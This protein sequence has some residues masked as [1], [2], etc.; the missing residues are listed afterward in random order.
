MLLDLLRENEI[1]SLE[2]VYSKCNCEFDALAGAL[3]SLIEKEEIR[4]GR[5]KTRAGWLIGNK[6][7]DTPAGGATWHTGR[8]QMRNSLPKILKE[9]KKYSPAQEI[10]LDDQLDHN[11]VKSITELLSDGQPRS[12]LQITAATG[13][14]NISSQTWRRFARLPDGRYTLP[15]SSG[16][17]EYFYEYVREKPRR[18]SD[19]LRIFQKHKNIRAIITAGDSQGKLIRLPHALLTTSDSPAGR[20]ELERRRQ[21]KLCNDTLNSLPSPFFTLEELEMNKSIFQSIADKHTVNA[22]LNGKEY[23]CLRR[24]FP[25]DIVTDQLVDITGRYF[26]PPARISAPAFLKTISMGE[27]ETLNFLGVEEEILNQLIQN[28]NIEAFYL[29]GKRRM[30]R[31]DVEQLKMNSPLLRDLSQKHEKLK[32]PRA[33]V[34]LGITTGQVRRL[35]NEGKLEPAGHCSKDANSGQLFTRRNIEEL[36]KSLPE[37]L[38]GW[39]S[40]EKTGGSGSRR[41]GKKQFLAPK[42]PLLR[43]ELTLDNQ[44]QLQL[45]RFQIEAVEALRAGHSVLLSAP[46]GNGKTLVAEILARDLMAAGN[47]MVYTSPLKALSNQ[48]YRDFKETFGLDAVGLVTGDISVNAGAPLLIM[49]TEIFRNWCLGEPEQLKKS[50]YVVFDEIHYLDD[51]ERGTTWE[52]SILFAPPHIKFLGLSATVPNI[53]EIAD[54][55]GSVRREK[56]IIIEEKKRQVPLKIC[57]VTPNGQIVEENEARQEVDELAEYLKAFRNRRQWAEE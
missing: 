53:R 45:D 30:W 6:E 1:L 52:E 34:L 19:L 36:Q 17:R 48:K 37:I 31:N 15:D 28:N 49:T 42:R 18:L 51:S 40:V 4:I 54:W 33:A 2:E 46:T 27:K 20:T 7:I 8:G 11:Q 56:V 32:I 57:W 3:S 13:I 5:L 55:I 10:L 22:V 9:L 47:G 44:H 26:D 25:G 21:L 29:D 41:C 24:E 23:F 39:S 16:A 12:R 50:T 43:K 35:V 38:S 14:E